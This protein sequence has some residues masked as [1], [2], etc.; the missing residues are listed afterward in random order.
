ME[1]K[2]LNPFFLLPIADFEL[3]DTLWNV[4]NT[5]NLQLLYLVRELIDTL[6]NV[7]KLVNIYPLI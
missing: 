4:N 3:I 2:L 5:T 1:C 7:N 6:W